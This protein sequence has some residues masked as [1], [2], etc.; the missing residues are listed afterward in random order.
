MKQ[1]EFV[2]DPHA[3]NPAA[4]VAMRALEAEARELGSERA[5]VAN[6]NSTQTKERGLADD[7][8]VV[9]ILGWGYG[10]NLTSQEPRF[11]EFLSHETE[12]GSHI[13]PSAVGACLDPPGE[14]SDCDLTLR[15]FVL[16]VAVRHR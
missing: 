10:R 8:M 11:M 4:D 1:R 13:D 15:S 16:F 6:L 7:S 14:C 5:A 12:P 3:Q 2:G 9:V